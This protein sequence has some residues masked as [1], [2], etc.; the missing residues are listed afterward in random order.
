MMGVLDKRQKRREARWEALMKAV[1]HL[2][3]SH[4]RG[5]SSDSLTITSVRPYSLIHVRVKESVSEKKAREVL[6]WLYLI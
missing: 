2:S 1:R 3:Q 6:N 5:Y 4:G